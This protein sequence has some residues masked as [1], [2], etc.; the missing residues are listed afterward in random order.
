MRDE[1]LTAFFAAQENKDLD[2]MMKVKN[3]LKSYLEEHS[4]HEQDQHLHGQIEAA[5]C[6]FRGHE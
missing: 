3:D 4:A 2:A 6:A 1:I 5:I